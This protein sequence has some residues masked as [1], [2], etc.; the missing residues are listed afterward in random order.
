MRAV[1]IPKIEPLV[2][3]A[4]VRK[5]KAEV[6]LQ[7]R[8][9]PKHSVEQVDGL[10]GL[11]YLE[12]RPENSFDRVVLV[13]TLNH[14][15][16]NHEDR[17]KVIKLARRILKPDGLILAVARACDSGEGVAKHMVHVGVPPA[18]L[19]LVNLGN[20][21]IAILKPQDGMFLSDFM[22]LNKRRDTPVATVREFLRNALKSRG[23]LPLADDQVQ[24]F[25]N[26]IRVKVLDIG[27]IWAK[28][29]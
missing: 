11:E 13:Y 7:Q 1:K 15:P 29:P 22:M 26:L 3:R 4:P 10:D 12:T 19:E 18:R 6:W 20:R 5:Q 17:R 23:P 8:I 2:L 9:D 28:E 14:V 16:D 21:D 25:P 24:S 27:M